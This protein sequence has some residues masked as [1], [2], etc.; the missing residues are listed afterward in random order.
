MRNLF[1]YKC[2]G[3]IKSG[4]YD[5]VNN[6]PVHTECE[7][8]GYLPKKSFCICCGKLITPYGDK[9]AALS[10][11]IIHENCLLYG[12][13]E[14]TKCVECGGLLTPYNPGFLGPYKKHIHVACYYTSVIGSPKVKKIDSTLNKTGRHIGR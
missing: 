14:P 2:G 13:S 1:Y 7:D 12:V 3:I 9:L 5:Y 4:N 10:Y 11:S 8:I 6:K